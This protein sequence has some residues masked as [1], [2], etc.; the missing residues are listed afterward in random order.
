MHDN[1][2][3]SFVDG[4]EKQK[5]NILSTVKFQY[6]NNERKEYVKWETIQ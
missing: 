2:E 1:D 5:Y 3:V 4:I 6:L